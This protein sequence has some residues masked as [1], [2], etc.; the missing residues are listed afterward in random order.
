MSYLLITKPTKK[1][2]LLGTFG[3]RTKTRIFQDSQHDS[4]SI[5]QYL[6]HRALI[7]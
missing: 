6:P 5:R 7:A 3:A 2:L 4:L 1:L